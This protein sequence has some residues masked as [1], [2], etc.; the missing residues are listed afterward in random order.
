MQGYVSESLSGLDFKTKYGLKPYGDTYYPLV[1]FGMYRDRDLR[2]YLQNKSYVT[3]VWTGSDALKLT[4]S[5]AAKINS[6][7]A[8]HYAISTWVQDKLASHGVDSFYSP[9]SA[10]IGKANPVPR[11]NSVYFYTSHTSQ[12]SSDHYGEYMIEEIKAKTGLNVITATYETY[13]KVKLNDVYRDCFVN[14]RLTKFDGL[15]NTNL[16][17]GLLGRRSIYNG[18]IPGSI[19]WRDVDDICD[20]I[21]WEYY[22]RHDDNT[23]IAEMTD[24]LVN[25]PNQLFKP[26]LTLI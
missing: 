11:G 21:M 1:I 8:T 24:I 15:P 20:A 12:E 7:P 3:V 10:T 6:R 18:S 2:I 16:E 14:L 22:K 9:I 26:K 19:K 5:W 25:S 4:A 23:E 13:D 17:M